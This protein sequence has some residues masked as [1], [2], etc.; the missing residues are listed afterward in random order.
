MTER[1]HESARQRRHEA[2]EE[3]RAKQD[4]KD[5]EKI[6]R[7]EVDR[8]RELGF[9]PKVN[10]KSLKKTKLMTQEKKNF[11]SLYFNLA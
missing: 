10:L 2:E 9:V 4:E 11:S 1:H 7:E 5:Y 3:Q 8:M 6:I